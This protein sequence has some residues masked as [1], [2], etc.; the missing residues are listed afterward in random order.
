MKDQYILVDNQI[1]DLQGLSVSDIMKLQPVKYAPIDIQK[2]ILNEFLK[3]NCT[4]R[5][6]DLII[7]NENFNYFFSYIQGIQVGISKPTPK[8]DKDFSVFWNSL[9]R[10]KLESLFLEHFSLRFIKKRLCSVS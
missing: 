8:D 9:L 1:I 10:L 4:E 5:E 6:M 7:V 3:K 2:T